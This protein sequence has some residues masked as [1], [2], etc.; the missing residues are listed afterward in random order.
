MRINRLIILMVLKEEGKGGA[1]GEKRRGEVEK[2]RGGREH[3]FIN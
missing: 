1:K 2:R 3:T